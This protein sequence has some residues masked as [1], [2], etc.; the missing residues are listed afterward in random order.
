[1][2]ESLT[3]LLDFLGLAWWVEIKTQSPQCT[4]YFGPFSSANE[5]ETAK[6]GYVEDLQ[7]E[8]AQGIVTE[9]KR[10]KPT[11][12]TIVHEGGEFRGNPSPSFS[13]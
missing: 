12:L 2:Q 8:G 10:C 13:S 5:A 9:V 6:P 4:Y 1:M 11:Q 7:G 3:S